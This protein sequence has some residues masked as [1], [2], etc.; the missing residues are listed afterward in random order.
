MTETDFSVIS[1]IAAWRWRAAEARRDK[2][3]LA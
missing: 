1:V 3:L 2:T